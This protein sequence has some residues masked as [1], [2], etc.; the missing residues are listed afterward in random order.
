M[1]LRSAS[2]NSA[3]HSCSARRTAQSRGA[4]GHIRVDD[5]DLFS[6]QVVRIENRRN[7]DL[8]V[9]WLE[10]RVTV[11]QV[12]TEQEVLGIKELV[13]VS[14]ESRLTGAVVLTGRRGNLAGLE[15][16]IRAGGEVQERMLPEDGV[17]AFQY[18]LV[19]R[20]NE[21][22]LLVRIVG[23]GR[24]P[25]TVTVPFGKADPP[26][27]LHGYEIT[28]RLSFPRQDARMGGKP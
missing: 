14:E 10:R 25:F 3:N 4:P 1:G 28:A 11:Q 6:H 26:T 22:A 7:P 13:R 21:L 17:I 2:L 15:H 27:V 23:H 18:V 12:N 19:V 20:I 5:A 16:R 9:R 8:P 24:M